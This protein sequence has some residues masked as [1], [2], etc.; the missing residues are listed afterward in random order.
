MMA[1]D[2]QTDPWNTPRLQKLIPSYD[3]GMI[4][5]LCKYELFTSHIKICLGCALKVKIRSFLK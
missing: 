5:W 4:D 1:R 2:G 3:F